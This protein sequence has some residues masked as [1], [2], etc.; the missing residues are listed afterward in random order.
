[1]CR[2]QLPVALM[3]ALTA[4]G[5]ERAP[6]TYASSCEGPLPHWGREKDGIGHLR[7]VQPV[8]LASDGSVLWNR[9]VISD[10]VLKRYMVTVSGMN[11]EPQAVL[12]VAP[13]ALCQRVKTV[14]AIMDSVP[15]CK[16]PHSLCSEG[17][18][19]KQWPL[20]GGS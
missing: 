11:P 18:N 9:A 16:G 4:A 7:A 2:H 6:E 20:A 15:L 1:M 10:A 14:R 19:W 3:L 8:Y 5:C 17:W 12:E 13:T